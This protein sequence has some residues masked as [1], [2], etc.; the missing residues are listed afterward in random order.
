MAGAN[1][2]IQ[3]S[4][5]DF[6]DIKNNLKLFLQSQDA[7]KDYNFEGSGLS[8]L[9]DIMAYNTQYNAYYLNQVANEMFLDSA[10]QRSS[11]VSHAKLLNYTP[12]SYIA[13][14]ATVNINFT[15]VTDSQLVLPAYTNFSSEA[16]DGINYNFVTTD[17]YYATTSD[18]TA[19]YTD[20]ELKQ[21]VIGNFNYVVDSSTNPSYTFEIPDANIDTTT[22]KVVVQ[23][24]SSNTSMDT[25][26]LSRDVLYLNGESK[27]FFLQ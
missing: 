17:D 1:S 20:V 15:G 10:T 27:V 11:V 5:L 3:L 19:T 16:I 25:Y 2:N 23:Q 8:V 22:I 24:S 12:K 14:T 9:L 21:G 13:P 26:S 18:G 4:T 7:F 6:N